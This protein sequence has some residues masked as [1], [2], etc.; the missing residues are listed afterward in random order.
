MNLSKTKE[1]KAV[2]VGKV[3]KNGEHKVALTSELLFIAHLSVWSYCCYLLLPTKFRENLAVG[4]CHCG[5]VDYARQG[6]TFSSWIFY[7][8]CKWDGLLQ[9]ELVSK[10]D[11]F[12]LILS[13]TKIKKKINELICQVTNLWAV[14]NGGHGGVPNFVLALYLFQMRLIYYSW[15][16][17]HFVVEGQLPKILNLMPLF[18]GSFVFVFAITI[19]PELC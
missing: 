1:R 15:T 17:S 3:E 14:I 16:Y 5:T 19:L 7:S 11:C 10:C 12:K 8:T 18:V 2:K 4:Y 9:I 13:F 6:K